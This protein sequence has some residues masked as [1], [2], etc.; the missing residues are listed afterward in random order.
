MDILQHCFECLNI[1]FQWRQYIV[2]SW[3]VNGFCCNY[4]VEI[5]PWKYYH[6]RVPVSCS[7]RRNLFENS[8][9]TIKT[10]NLQPTAYISNHLSYVNRLDYPN[11]FQTFYII[12]FINSCTGIDTCTRCKTRLTIWHLLDL[13]IHIISSHS[14]SSKTVAAKCL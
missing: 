6:K 9:C 4:Y 13:Q 3:S 12:F 10:A 5:Y 2:T 7:W 11:M 1:P 14:R 8:Q